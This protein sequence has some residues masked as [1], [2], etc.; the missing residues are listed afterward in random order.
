MPGLGPIEIMVV[1]FDGSHF[2]GEILPELER[3]KESDIVRLV[4]LLVVRKDRSGAL[5]VMTATD[6]DMQE[7]LEFG[8]KVGSLIASGI[9]TDARVEGAL[10][11]LDVVSTGHV[12]DEKE[13]QRLA[14]ELPPGFAAAVVI[15]EHR[16]AIPL[17]E[18]IARADGVIL[19]EEWLTPNRLVELGRSSPLADSAPIQP[20]NGHGAE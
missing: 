11:G 14:A 16:W 19:S 17:R 7:M 8:A 10:A 6:L 13:A 9:A 15:L 5:A 4:D 3:L 1:D 12:F 2:R 18:A 20:G